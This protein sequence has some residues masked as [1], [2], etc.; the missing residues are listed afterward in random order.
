LQLFRAL[1]AYIWLFFCRGGFWLFLVVFGCFLLF[2]IVSLLIS[3]CGADR[4]DVNVRLKVAMSSAKLPLARFTKARI[5]SAATL[6][7]ILVCVILMAITAWNA[8]RGYE[9]EMQDAETATENMARALSQQADDTFRLAGV[10]L[11]GIS[12]R[13]S[14]DGV[15]PEAL[16]RLHELFELLVSEQPELTG[17]YIVDKEGNWLVNASVPPGSNN[18]NREYFIHHKYDVDLSPYVGVPVL[19]RLPHRWVIPVSRRLDDRNGQFFG[20]VVAAIELDYFNRFYS[21][22]DIGRDG[23]ILLMLNRGP[24]LTRWPLLPDSIGK[25]MAGGPVLRMRT[26]LRDSGNAIVIAPSDGVERLIGYD[27]L[28]HFPAVAVAALSKQEILSGW[29]KATL[30]QGAAILVVVGVLGF[31]GSRLVAQI[32]LRMQAEEEARHA[33]EAMLTLNHTLEKLALQD[34]LTG[35]ANRRQFDTVFENELS[36]ARRS[37]NSLALIMIDVDC[38]KRYN[39]IYGHLAGDECLR[40]ISRIILTAEVRAG[41][42]AAR[43][44][45]EE[46]AVLLPSTDVQGALKVAEEIRQAVWKLAI[47]HEGNAYGVVTISAGVDA[48]T[49]VAGTDTSS[50]LIAAADEALYEAKL[51]G[52]NQTRTYQLI[53]SGSRS[54]S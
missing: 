15:S 37:V 29:Y 34:G 46:F 49:P 32:G 11:A 51:G 52:R 5:T 41:D 24:L 50:I 30:T 38:F 1:T 27:H 35:L 13:V 4:N 40:K 6:F 12:E 39:D 23:A 26:T 21:G 10:T 14:R 33:G 47:K 31:L 48:F 43:Y 28:G 16:L 17:L 22:Y 54:V 25:D 45:G 9:Q 42:L 20:V 2:L 44:G 19:S 36:R 8:W 53:G 7:V 3:F 18:V